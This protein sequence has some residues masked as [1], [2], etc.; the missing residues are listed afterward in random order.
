MFKHLECIIKSPIEVEK[1]NLSPNTSRRP[2]FEQARHW[3]STC[4]KQHSHCSGGKPDE[5]PTRLIKAEREGSTFSAL[6]CDSVDLH[7]HIEYLTLSHCWGQIPFLTLTEENI[8]QMK[9]SI[10]MK[11][12]PQVFQDAMLTTMELGFSYLWIDSLCIIQNSPGSSDWLSESSTMDQAWQR[13][14]RHQY[15]INT[16]WYYSGITNIN[17][18]RYRIDSYTAFYPAPF[19]F[20]SLCFSYL[21]LQFHLDYTLKISSLS[22]LDSFF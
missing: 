3:L 15:G 18:Y 13:Y 12:L 16:R 4:L 7:G 2:L 1:R 21:I 14:L 6:L 10:P 22:K 9:C 5:L 20:Y 19:N 17:T 11:E 8:S